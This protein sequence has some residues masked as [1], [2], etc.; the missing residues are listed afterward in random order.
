MAAEGLLIATPPGDYDDAYALAYA[1]RHGGILVSNDR[2]N[3]AVAT[4]PPGK[5]RDALRAWLRARVCTFA[6][7]GAEFLPNPAFTF[8]A[9]AEEARGGATDEEGAPAEEL[10]AAA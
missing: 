3:D 1:R 4:A 6:F 7:A 2:Y 8:R 10:A 5:R 9:A